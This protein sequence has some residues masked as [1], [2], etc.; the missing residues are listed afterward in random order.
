MLLRAPV[1]SVGS[2]SRRERT[3]ATRSRVGRSP[4]AWIAT[5]PP[6][7]MRTSPGPSTRS[8][9]VSESAATRRSPVM[10]TH[11]ASDAIGSHG[12]QKPKPGSST[13]AVTATEPGAAPIAPS[14]ARSLPDA[15]SFGR[16]RMRA[17][18][19]PGRSEVTASRPSKAKRGGP[20]PLGAA[21]TQ[22]QLSGMPGPLHLHGEAAARQATRDRR[23]VSCASSRSLAGQTTGA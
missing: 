1:A 5:W 3:R 14:K 23:S 6:S 21:T 11:H 4:H 13:T 22:R 18:R 16:D 9:P 2:Q 8:S 20:I 15:G 12:V 10:T 7:S 19:T 17:M